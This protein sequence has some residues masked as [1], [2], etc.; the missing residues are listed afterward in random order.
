MHGKKVRHLGCFDDDREAAQAVDTA[1]R[2]YGTVFFPPFY[3]ENDIFTK[4]G[5]GQT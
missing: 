1:A 2:R 3:T 4:T 5:S